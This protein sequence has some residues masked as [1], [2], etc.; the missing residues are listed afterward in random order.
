M[1]VELNSMAELQVGQNFCRE[2]WKQ[3]E[4]QTAHACHVEEPFE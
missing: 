4:R 1:A 3:R 2:W